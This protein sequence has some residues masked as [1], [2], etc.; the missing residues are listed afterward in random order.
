MYIIG[1]GESRLSVDVGSLNGPIVGCNAICRDYRVDHLV[2]VDKRMVNEA[3]STSFFRNTR[4]YTRQDWWFQYRLYDNVGPVPDLPY[5]GT[6]KWDKPFHWGSGPYAV[7]IGAMKS[8][9]VNMIGF[10]LYSKNGKINNI[11]KGT[12]NYNSRDFR[13]VDPSYWI[14]QIEKVFEHFPDVSFRIYNTPDWKCPSEW[15]KFNVQVDSISN[16]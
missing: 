5:S 2:C 4:V 15:K 14:Y 7:L 6:Q 11:Y 12:E 3:L 10:D 16:L 8:S 13:A 1:N 9:L